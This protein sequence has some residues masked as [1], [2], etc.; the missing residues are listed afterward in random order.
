[1]S[2]PLAVQKRSERSNTHTHT[3]TR[4]LRRFAWRVPDLT[5]PILAQQPFR[6][7]RESQ[8]RKVCTLPLSNTSLALLEPSLLPLWLVFWWKLT[9]DWKKKSKKKPHAMLLLLMWYLIESPKTASWNLVATEQLRAYLPRWHTVQTTNERADS[10]ATF[11]R[12]QMNS[13]R[14]SLAAAVSRTCACLV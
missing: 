3:H 14:T 9:K 11:D 13:K 12:E 8:Q 1:M 2:L 7:G 6:K 5:H 10:G 4:G